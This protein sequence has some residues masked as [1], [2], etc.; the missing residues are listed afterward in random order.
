MDTES[1]RIKMGEK[2][3]VVCGSRGI[4]RLL[5]FKTFDYFAASRG[6]GDIGLL[7]HGDS[8]NVDKTLA[9]AWPDLDG[10]CI[11]KAYPADWDKYGRAAG[12]IRNEQMAKDADVC[13][14]LWDG[15][16][17]GTLDMIKRADGYG[18]ELY[19]YVVGEGER[20]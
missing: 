4:D 11:S 20:V 16:S 10:L 15:E 1:I 8:G 14:A 18:L 6:V 19:V 3:L 2:V 13:F 12:P 17:R 9:Q 7:I 5:A